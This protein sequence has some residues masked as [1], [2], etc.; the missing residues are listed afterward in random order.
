MI[1]NSKFKDYYD[2]VA[3][4]YR[5]EK[6]VYSR[7]TSVK[8]SNNGDQELLKFASEHTWNYSSWSWSNREA[9]QKEDMN[10]LLVGGKVYPFTTISVQ[11]RE[12]GQSPWDF[13]NPYCDYDKT[14]AKGGRIKGISSTRR[15]M[16]YMMKAYSKLE[17][18][19]RNEIAVKLCQQ[20]APVMILHGSQEYDAGQARYKQHYT[21]N[22]NLSDY[23]PGIDAWV[24]VQDIMS[25]LGS[26]EPHIP[27]MDDKTRIEAAGFDIKKSFRHRK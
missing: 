16:P 26:V 20:Y 14:A 5:D 12:H 3:H 11:E 13:K 15:D 4:Q 22:P 9:T 18:G 21:L 24:V 27:E 6:V 2:Y 7:K 23:K 10:L 25:I 8:E 1:I 19:A 17:S